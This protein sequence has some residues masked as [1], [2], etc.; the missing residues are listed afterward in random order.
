MEGILVG[1][2][3]PLKL[4]EGS[5]NQQSWVSVSEKKGG[6]LCGMVWDNSGVTLDGREFCWTG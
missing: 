3:R 1:Q 2:V 6:D 4:G 5:N